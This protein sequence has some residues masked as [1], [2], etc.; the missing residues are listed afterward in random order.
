MQP[1]ACSQGKGVATD[2][3]DEFIPT[4]IVLGEIDLSVRAFGQAVTEREDILLTPIQQIH[5]YILH[6]TYTQLSSMQ[7]LRSWGVARGISGEMLQGR[8]K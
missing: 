5:C 6:I 2:L 3:H 1:A 8:R 7:Y 4:S